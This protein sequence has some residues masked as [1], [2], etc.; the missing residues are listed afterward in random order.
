MGGGNGALYIHVDDFVF[1]HENEDV[2]NRA[3]AV[4]GAALT[5]V[6]FVVEYTPSY[7]IFKVVGLEVSRVGGPTLDI[8]LKK[9]GDLDRALEL[10]K[11]MP[12]ISPGLVRV[13]ASI[14]SWY[15]LMWR[16]AFSAF[17][18]IFQWIQRFETSKA[19]VPW[20]GVRIAFRRM[21]AFLPFIYADLG[22]KLAPFLLA[23]DAAGPSP[24][25]VQGPTGS[26]SL[27]VG[28]PNLEDLSKMGLS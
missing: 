7:K 21:R 19:A 28:F 8:P 2:R 20:D 9:L 4:V 25:G 10:F 26:F 3:A 11:E 5:K 23:Q 27:A 17:G 15:A 6:G 14:F 16:G 13:V 12:L 24:L 22:R 1:C 18:P